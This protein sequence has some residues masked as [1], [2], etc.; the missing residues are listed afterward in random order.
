MKLGAWGASTRFCDSSAPFDVLTSNRSPAAVTE[1]ALMFRGLT[2]SSLIM[3][4]IHTM[5]ASS[6]W[7]LG[8]AVYGPSFLPSRKPSV[9]R[10]TTSQRLVTIQSRL[11]STSGA[12]QMPWSG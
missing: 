7:V 11:P 4:K 2:P 3:S 12:Q 5:S 1:Q 8:S 6:R 9:S 10:Q